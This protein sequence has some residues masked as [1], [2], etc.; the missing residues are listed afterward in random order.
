[1]RSVYR[2]TGWVLAVVGVAPPGLCSWQ[3]SGRPPGRKQTVMACRPV[4]G[5]CVV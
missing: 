2:Y 5:G 3:C 1:M 4:T